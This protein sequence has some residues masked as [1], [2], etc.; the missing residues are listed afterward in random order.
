MW[1]YTAVRLAIFLACLGVLFLVGM[2]G[3]LLFIVAL[4]VS[5]LLSYPLARRPRD[6]MVRSYQQNRRGNDD[7]PGRS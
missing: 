4:L 1:R 2:R 5:G 7:G 6:A 3:L